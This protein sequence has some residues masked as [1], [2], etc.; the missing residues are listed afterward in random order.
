MDNNYDITGSTK[1]LKATEVSYYDY[2][3]TYDPI[4]FI[5][6]IK[7]L[8]SGSRILYGQSLLYQELFYFVDWIEHGEHRNIM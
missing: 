5:P 4:S 3:I 1:L 2:V 7:T 6:V 8:K